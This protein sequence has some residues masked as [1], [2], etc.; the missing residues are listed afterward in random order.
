MQ[1][2][3]DN[4]AISASV[5]KEGGAETVPAP[6]KSPTK[7]PAKSSKPFRVAFM[8]TGHFR[9]WSQKNRAFWVDFVARHPE[10]DF[11]VHTWDETG[12]RP[13]G[14]NRT[15]WIQLGSGNPEIDDIRGVLKPESIVV[16]NN[17]RLI[18]SFSLDT[19]SNYL[20]YCPGQSLRVPDFSRFI[21]SQLYSI[22]R[23][24]ELV[25]AHQAEHKFEYDVVFK[26]RADKS[27]V[28]GMDLARL[29]TLPMHERIMYVYSHANHKHPGGGRGCKAC[30]AEFATTAGSGTGAASGEPS[31]EQRALTPRKHHTH[32][33]DVC[34]VMFYGSARVMAK[35]ASLYLTVGQQYAQFERHNE[36]QRHSG[37][38]IDAEGN[39]KI[40]VEGRRVQIVPGQWYERHFRCIYPEAFVRYFMSQEWLLSD[41]LRIKCV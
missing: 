9:Q 31:V 40:I 11:F 37:R 24:F 28:E 25:V 41:P 21:V 6:T 32:M 8:M 30:D 14:R 27:P 12:V 20:Y 22:H 3:V 33:N 26:L 36:K 38:F 7:S 13:R 23:C 2:L 4:L 19:G 39:G 5:D 10:V 1:L 16:E 29:R 15:T 18:E 35:Y 17:E 34:D